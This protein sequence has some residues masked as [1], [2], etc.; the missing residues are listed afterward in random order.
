MGNVGSCSI[1]RCKALRVPRRRRTGEDGDAMRSRAFVISVSNLVAIALAFS[2]TCPAADISAEM[3]ALLSDVLKPYQVGGPVPA[4]V[5][6]QVFARTLAILK[7]E[8][9]VG[10]PRPTTSSTDIADRFG[11]ALALGTRSHQFLGEI[12]A[13]HDA[14]TRGDAQ[15]VEEAIRNLYRKAGRSA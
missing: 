10:L 4:G 14:L 7:K 11:K 3:S 2:L 8:G 6:P 1:R 5:D 13:V 15:A 9:L 12:G